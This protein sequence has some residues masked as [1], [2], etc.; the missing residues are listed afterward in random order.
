[1]S[2]RVVAAD[3]TPG[4]HA[5]TV[6]VSG[7]KNPLSSG[8]GISLD[9]VGVLAGTDVGSNMVIGAVYAWLNPSTSDQPSSSSDSVLQV[10]GRSASIQSA[11]EAA[12]DGDVIVVAPGTYRENIDFLGKRIVLRSGQP[13]NPEIVAST[14]IDA[15]SPGATVLFAAGESREASLEGFTLRNGQGHCVIEVYGADPTISKNIIRGSTSGA[16]YLC[17]TES[18]WIIGNT[19]ENNEASMGVINCFHASPMI[20][21]NLLIEN[22]GS[23]INTYFS[24]PMIINNTIRDNTDNHGTAAAIYLDHFSPAT[25]RGNAISRTRSHAEY[26]GAAIILDF[27][28]NARIE[29]NII[30]DNFGDG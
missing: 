4:E 21:N 1:K 8:Y 5:L 29:G 12:E 26:G 6:T 20:E 17:Y 19:I 10:P 18:A 27:F 15:E 2:E 14:I 9:A 28:S 30:A 24:S 3:L 7:D 16:I 25:L 11:I 23:A 22:T 13:D